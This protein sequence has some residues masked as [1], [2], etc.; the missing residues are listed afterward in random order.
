MAMATAMATLLE[1]V[2]RTTGMATRPAMALA[3]ATVGLLSKVEETYCSRSLGNGN[4]AGNGNQAGNGN[5][6]GNHADGNSASNSQG[7]GNS[8]S[9]SQGNG[10][11]IKVAP[12]VPRRSVR[13]IL[14]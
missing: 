3:P 14:Y 9:N 8:A 12:I 7:N 1:M 2:I 5:G 4:K 13:S 10:E 6:S 11:W